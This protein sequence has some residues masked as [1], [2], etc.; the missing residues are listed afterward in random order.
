MSVPMGTKA[1]RVI[2]FIVELRAEKAKGD[3]GG[4]DMQ[5]R[6]RERFEGP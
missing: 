5:E 1:G 6:S 4:K 3:S 2:V